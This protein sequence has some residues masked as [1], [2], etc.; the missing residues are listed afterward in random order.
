MRSSGCA[1]EGRAPRR[2]TGIGSALL[3]AGGSGAGEGATPGY[4][5]FA[6]GGRLC[7]GEA[8]VAGSSLL[9]RVKGGVAVLAGAA[10]SPRRAL[11][12]FVI[13]LGWA[14]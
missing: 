6:A 8:V 14:L 5:A 9:V 7:C 3:L 2:R 13:K 12:T 11:L 4:G 1:G 10:G